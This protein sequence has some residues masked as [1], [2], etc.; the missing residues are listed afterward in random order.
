M[1][2]ALIGF[3]KSE[4]MTLARWVGTCQLCEGVPEFCALSN[5]KPLFLSRR[6]RTEREEAQLDQTLLEQAVAEV[7][8][9][10]LAVLTE[11]DLP[12][13]DVLSRRGSRRRVDH[14]PLTHPAVLL[15]APSRRSQLP[16]GRARALLRI[17]VN[18]PLPALLPAR[19]ECA[20]AR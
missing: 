4:I 11:A 18:G 19:R 8:E 17:A 5:S 16:A 13:A 7:R 10:D 20:D 15:L 9:I 2:R 14:R 6:V 1:L 3:D 12:E